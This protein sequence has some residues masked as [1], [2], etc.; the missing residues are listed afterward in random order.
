MGVKMHRIRRENSGTKSRSDWEYKS[1]MIACPLRRDV[2]WTS[3]K[4]DILRE[5]CP[6]LA[7]GSIP[8]AASLVRVMLGPLVFSKSE[9]ALRRPKRTANELRAL[10]RQRSAKLGPWPAG[11]TM[12]VYRSNDSW[13]VM[14]SP[15]KDPPEE[16]YR[17]RALWIAVQMQ[18]EFDLRGPYAP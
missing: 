16:N 5:N 12:F 14:I 8:D 6:A 3:E 11:M 13:E 1:Q 9:H 7:S 2:H 18:G 10:I 17:V 4:D 15:G